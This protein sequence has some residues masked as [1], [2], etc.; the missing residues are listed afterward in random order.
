M[1]GSDHWD[2]ESQ[3]IRVLVLR[4][5]ELLGRTAECSD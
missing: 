3:L 1:Q 2:V 4:T 5:G